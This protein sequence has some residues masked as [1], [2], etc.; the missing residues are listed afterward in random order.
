[1]AIEAVVGHMKWNQR[2]AM[3]SRRRLVKVRGEFSLMCLVHNVKK[4][5]E[6][7]LAGTVNLPGKY[8]GLAGMATVSILY[9]IATG[10]SFEENQSGSEPHG[11]LP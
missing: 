1:M 5:V 8:S 11:S 10:V 3:M 2:K 7:V 6:G 4:V 9:G